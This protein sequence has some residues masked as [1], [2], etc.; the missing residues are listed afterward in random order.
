MQTT[1]SVHVSP[2]LVDAATQAAT[3]FFEMSP[4]KRRRVFSDDGNSERN[5]MVFRS[6][7]VIAMWMFVAHS[8]LKAALRAVEPGPSL[9]SHCWLSPCH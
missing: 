1:E 7:D 9:S 4:L 2:C 3:E 6:A 5:S 8:S